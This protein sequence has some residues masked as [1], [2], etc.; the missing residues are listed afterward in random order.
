MKLRNKT[1]HLLNELLWKKTAFLCPEH[2][3]LIWEHT[4]STSPLRKWTVDAYV[5]LFGQ[6][7]L[8]QHDSSY[9]ADF[10][11]QVAI[12]AMGLMKDEVTDKAGMYE[13]MKT[14]MESEDK[15]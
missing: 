9:P 3:Q 4:P 2:C 1:L 8:K 10:V 5:T 14:Y 11:L 15:A 6:N 13:R 7:I 12:K